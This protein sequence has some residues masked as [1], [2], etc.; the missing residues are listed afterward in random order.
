MPLGLESVVDNAVS[1]LGLIRGG[2]E[3]LTENSCAVFST[4]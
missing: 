2:V 4:I 3:Q 1:S